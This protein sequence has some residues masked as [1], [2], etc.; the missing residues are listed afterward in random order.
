MAYYPHALPDNFFNKFQKNGIFAP[1]IDALKEDKELILFFRGK[2]VSIYYKGCRVCELRPKGGFKIDENYRSAPNELTF[3]APN[4]QWQKTQWANFFKNVKE[5]IDYYNKKIQ[6]KEEKTIQQD[7]VQHNNFGNASLTTDYFILDVENNQKLPGDRRYARFD[8]IALLFSKEDRLHH[9]YKNMKL[10]F[11]ELKQ[12]NAAAHGTSGV[13]EHYLKTV[14]LW[15]YLS[16]HQKEEF[17]DDMTRLAKQF[18]ALGLWNLALPDDIELSREMPTLIF[19]MVNHK[20]TNAI[21]NALQK[22]EKQGIN[23]TNAEPKILHISSAEIK[24]GLYQ[25]DLMTFQEFIDKYENKH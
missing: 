21:S 11:I 9:N 8:A 10:A 18:S 22:I 12:K 25:K 14:E 1:L 19:L 5:N 23:T 16:A 15:R 6:D 20:P 4:E 17:F 24:N 13:A 7:I 3:P 2:Y